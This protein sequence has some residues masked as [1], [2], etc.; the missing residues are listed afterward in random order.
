MAFRQARAKMSDHLARKLLP[1]TDGHFR[2]LPQQTGRQIP[3]IEPISSPGRIAD[4]LHL[5]CRQGLDLTV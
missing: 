2:R 1:D 3:R 4:V 5:R